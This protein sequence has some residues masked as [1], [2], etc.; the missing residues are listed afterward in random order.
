MATDDTWTMATGDDNGKPLIFRIRNKAPSFARKES[1]PHLLAVCWQYESPNNQGMPSQE[2]VERMSQ[3]EDLLEAAF[4]G[5]RQA[6]LTVI[7]TGNGIREWQWYARD[8]DAVMQLVNETLG[9]YEPFPVQF[10]FQD[11]P[12]WEGYS[13]FLD[14][15]DS[16]V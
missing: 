1:F 14:I 16:E 15:T 10:S 4:E 7:V 12:E 2:T 8:P 5:A 9:E 6:F 3:L 11:D 13:R